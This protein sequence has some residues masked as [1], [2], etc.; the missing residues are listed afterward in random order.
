M[1]ANANRASGKENGDTDSYTETH[2]TAGHVLTP[3]SGRDTKLPGVL[4]SA[5]AI[6]AN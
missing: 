5:N 6:A 4:A 1:F 3:G 2:I